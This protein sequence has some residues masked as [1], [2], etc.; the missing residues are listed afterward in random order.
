MAKASIILI[1]LL[2]GM[3]VCPLWSQ[4]IFFT[5]NF[6]NNS[7]GWVL[8]SSWIIFP[9]YSCLSLLHPTADSTGYDVSAYS[10]LITLPA[11]GINIAL[12]MLIEE[13]GGFGGRDF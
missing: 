10:P 12:N 1:I 3:C 11:T 4:D 13:D 6:T 9:P 8:G 5:E 2:V 7:T